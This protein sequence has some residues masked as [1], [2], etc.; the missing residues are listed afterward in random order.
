MDGK[1]PSEAWKIR[2]LWRLKIELVEILVKG[3]TILDLKTSIL[4]SSCTVSYTDEHQALD[5]GYA[6]A[7]ETDSDLSGGDGDVEQ[8]DESSESE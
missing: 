7:K 4:P 1:L 3:L 5:T 6:S 2:E 8:A